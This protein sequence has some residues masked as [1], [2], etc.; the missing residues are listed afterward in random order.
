MEASRGALH[1]LSLPNSDWTDTLIVLLSL[2]T[3]V[4][5]RTTLC[6]FPGD[7]HASVGYHP[8]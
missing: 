8:L 6:P 5:G 1:V 4:S 2:V 3:I 7:A